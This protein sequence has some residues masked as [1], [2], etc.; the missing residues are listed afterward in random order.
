[1][2]L[3]I[4]GIHRSARLW[5]LLLWIFLSLVGHIA[6]FD[7]SV[8]WK[9]LPHCLVMPSQRDAIPPQNGMTDHK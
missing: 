1:V 8:I 2:S 3:R 6:P 7:T 5:L 9:G 4:R